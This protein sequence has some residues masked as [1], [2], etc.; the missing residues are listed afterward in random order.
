MSQNNRH[1]QDK[2]DAFQAQE[3]FDSMHDP[4]LAILKAKIR[5][6]EAEVEEL[7]EYKFMY[8]GLQ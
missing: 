5:E 1:N 2:Y 4:R 3:E 8:E 6:L 7:R